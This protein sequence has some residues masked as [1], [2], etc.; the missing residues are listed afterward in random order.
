LPEQGQI[1]SLV[2][3]GGFSSQIKTKHT[4]GTQGERNAGLMAVCEEYY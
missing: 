1:D 4:T 2:R 3:I